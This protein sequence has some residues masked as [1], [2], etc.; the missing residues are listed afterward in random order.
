MTAEEKSKEIIKK[1]CNVINQSDFHIPAYISGV[2][3]ESEAY[4]N[5]LESETNSLSI[6]CA[7]IVVDEILLA[8]PTWFIDQ[9]KSTH[10]YW[11]EVKKILININNKE[12]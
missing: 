6:Q 10:K 5:I 1:F 12:I 9:M 3:N 2:D 7:L 8:N 11:E 4:E